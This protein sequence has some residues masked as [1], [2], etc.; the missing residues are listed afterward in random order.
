MTSNQTTDRDIEQA[1]A[2][3]AEDAAPRSAPDRLL[4]STFA[5]TMGSRQERVYPWLKL[6]PRTRAL[7]YSG[8]AAR[9]AL[10]GLVLM[11][12]L[13]LGAGFIGGAFRPTIKP[14]PSPEI[15]PSPQPTATARPTAVPRPGLN[16]VPQASLS[17]GLPVVAD[18]TIEVTNPLAM[19]SDG[20]SLWV[21]AADGRIDRIDP[22]S[23]S[24]VDSLTTLPKTDEYDGLAVDDG[25]LWATD[26]TAG[27]VFRV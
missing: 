25:E 19:V 20:N 13:A 6:R 7:T 24:T 10:V 8:S 5:R 12:A 1:L 4:E 11:V 9:F 23:A 22:A 26:F 16:T 3:W 14:S 15:S 18:A 27:R 17:A 21:L 2:E